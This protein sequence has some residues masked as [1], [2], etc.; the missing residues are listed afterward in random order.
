MQNAS[1]TPPVRLRFRSLRLALAMLPIVASAAVFTTA[2][3]DGVL[4]VEP[5]SVYVLT[6]VNGEP[7]P[8]VLVVSQS[9]VIVLRSDTLRFLE[10]GRYERAAWIE[11][12]DAR[13]QS[14]S[15]MRA[16]ST[17]IIQPAGDTFTLV[18]DVCADPRSLAL[19]VAPDTLRMVSGGL[20]LKGPISPAGTKRFEA[21]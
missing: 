17:G 4:D 19:C 8:A 18:D 14:G 2:C 9:G 3:G 12:R 13:G 20:V 21:R 1:P 10:A 11:E 7:L 15:P 5:G 6:L 16:Y